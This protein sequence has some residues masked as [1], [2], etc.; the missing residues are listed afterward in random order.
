MEGLSIVT[1]GGEGAGQEVMSDFGDMSSTPSSPNV[2]AL[3]TPPSNSRVLLSSSSSSS[4]SSSASSADIDGND[5]VEVARKKEKLPQSSSHSDV[6]ARAVEMVANYSP[7]DDHDD[8]VDKQADRDHGHDANRGHEHDAYHGHGDVDDDVRRAAAGSASGSGPRSGSGSGSD[9]ASDYESYSGY[10]ASGAAAAAL[11]VSEGELTRRL[12][13][14]RKML[15]E[16]RASMGSET[17]S[18]NGGS[19]TDRVPAP[20]LLRT[21]RLRAGSRVQSMRLAAVDESE[22]ELALDAEERLPLVR[23]VLVA[24]HKMLVAT[25]DGQDALAD[26]SQRLAGVVSEVRAKLGEAGRDSTAVASGLATVE[27]QAAALTTATTR[28]LHIGATEEN[29]DA[30]ATSIREL[31][32]GLSLL[33]ATFRFKRAFAGEG[34]EVLAFWYSLAQGNPLVGSSDTS[35]RRGSSGDLMDMYMDVALGVASDSPNPLV[36]RVASELA[37]IERLAHEHSTPGGSGRGSSASPGTPFMP[38]EPPDDGEWC[39]ESTIDEALLLAGGFEPIDEADGGPGGPEEAPEPRQPRQPRQPRATGQAGERQRRRRRKARAASSINTSTAS[40]SSYSTTSSYSSSSSSTGGSTSRSTTG[41]GRA[42]RA[43]R[44]ST[45]T[46]ITLSSMD[47]DVLRAARQEGT[48]G[49]LATSS[50]AAWAHAR[51]AAPEPLNRSESKI[52]AS[53]FRVTDAA[54]A[55]AAAAER[56]RREDEAQRAQLAEAE[57][58]DRILVAALLQSLRNQDQ[59]K[60]RLAQQRARVSEQE[61]VKARLEHKIQTMKKRGYMPMA[62]RRRQERKLNASLGG[63]AV[64]DVSELLRRATQDSLDLPP[65]ESLDEEIDMLEAE[66]GTIDKVLSLDV[67]QPYLSQPSFSDTSS[68]ALFHEVMAVSGQA[69]RSMMASRATTTGEATTSGGGSGYNPSMDACSMNGH[70]AKCSTS[71]MPSFNTSHQL[72]CDVP[73]ASVSKLLDLQDGIIALDCVTNGTTCGVYVWHHQNGPP[74]IFNC[75]LEECG[76]EYKENHVTLKCATTRCVHGPNWTPS[77]ILEN[78]LTSL[79]GWMSFDCDLR[80]NHCVMAQEELQELIIPLSCYSGDCVPYDFHPPPQYYPP[81]WTRENKIIVG[82]IAA[83]MGLA[84][85]GALAYYFHRRRQA[86]YARL[87]EE[88]AVLDIDALA[89]DELDKYMFDLGFADLSVVVKDKTILRSASGYCAPGT[90]TAIMGPSGAGK[91]TLLNVLAG[92]I[93]FSDMSGQVLVNGQ[94]RSTAFKRIAGY[95]TQDD[96]LIPTLTV[97]ETLNFHAQLRLGNSVSAATRVARVEKVIAQLELTHVADSRIGD[98]LIRGISGGERRRVS[99]ATELVTSPRILFLDEPTS[100]LDSCTASAIMATLRELATSSALTVILS[101]HQPRSSIYASFDNLILLSK[102]S[103]LYNGRAA[104]ATGHFAQLGHPCPQDFNPADFLIDLVTASPATT[105]DTLAYHYTTSPAATT[106]NNVLDDLVQ[107]GISPPVPRRIASLSPAVGDAAGLLALLPGVQ[108]ARS[109]NR[110]RTVSGRLIDTFTIGTEETEEGSE[111]SG[112]SRLNSG[113]PAVPRLTTSATSLQAEA[114]SADGRGSGPA[115]ARSDAS[116]RYEEVLDAAGT[117]GDGSGRG[118]MVRVFYDNQAQLSPY[119]TSA[120]AQTWILCQRTALNVVRN[121]ALG[122]A[123]YVVTIVVGLIIGG[124][125]FQVGDDWPGLQNRAGSVFFIISLL[126]FGS[127]SAL[128]LFIAERALFLHE[129][130]NGCYRS[131]SYFVSKLVCDLIPLRIVPPVILAV[132]AYYLIGLR[133][134]A[135]HFVWFAFVLVLVDINATGMCMAIG[136]IV[137]S[138]AVGNLITVLVML[139][140]MLFGGFLL[141]KSTVGPLFIWLKYLSF[142]NYGYE[143]ALVDQLKGTVINFETSPGVSVLLT[144]EAVLARLSLNPANFDRDILILIGMGAGHLLLAYLMLRVRAWLRR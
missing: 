30:V 141:N 139:F 62:E 125:Y 33:L 86:A 4:S 44:V 132:I 70:E 6:L 25:F 17:G 143:A 31:V 63:V 22:E 137:P 59:L 79:K 135:E 99:I 133:A 11:M 104:G 73:D 117:G 142:F 89:A 107:R 130:S 3:A 105:L 54:A 50:T 45:S 56:A 49:R 32:T 122:L 78:I 84:A 83:A 140:Y 75:V 115:S 106:L 43:R 21:R 5:K 42:G 93:S 2:A 82:S 20:A 124:I 77:E 128:E 123:H 37:A 64:G 52:G 111:R 114:G 38:A 88:T 51:L 98:R 129:R 67:V 119:A 116:A 97:R 19:E 102:G 36:M 90:V 10:S 81:F 80:N 138:V 94:P 58:Q 108:G 120:L 47:S 69:G 100:G 121:P 91:S 16:S 66:L 55:A 41:G 126:S 92:R 109:E 46:D 39:T 24:A 103:T 61:V 57:R 144:G 85:L 34:E 127:L 96:F 9:S 71:L 14:S 29:Y 113:A 27:V 28:V 26:E 23:R 134:G 110:E 13:E 131:S 15:T 35:S 101:I 53:V 112:R 7:H 74:E 40:S 118:E 72:Q 60:A 87:L 48:F 95:V 136:A 8:N 65:P 76:Y 1:E 68:K 18:A 12:M